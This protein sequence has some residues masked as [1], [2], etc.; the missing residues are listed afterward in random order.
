MKKLIFVFAMLISGILINAQEITTKYNLSLDG[1]QGTEISISSEKI[2]QAGE[3][4][5]EPSTA[6]I[7][8]FNLEY[9]ENGTAKSL[10]TK[11]RTITKEMKEVIAKMNPGDSFNITGIVLG[12]LKAVYSAPD[13]KVVIVE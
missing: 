6:Q 7:L 11:S 1:K 12:E 2:L 9:T 3:I 4:R 5:I 10:S 13:I 8:A